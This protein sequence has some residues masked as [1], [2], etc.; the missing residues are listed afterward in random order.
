MD[1]IDE[2]YSAIGVFQ[3]PEHALETFLKIAAILGA[4]DQCAKIE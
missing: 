4:R 2:Q 1:L 3:L